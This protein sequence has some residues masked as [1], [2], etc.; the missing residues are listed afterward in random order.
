MARPRAG[1]FAGVFGGKKWFEN[2]ANFFRWDA[3]ALI[4]DC[5]CNGALCDSCCN[6]DHTVR[7]RCI[8]GIR[9]N[10]NKYLGKPLCIAEYK[11]LLRLDH[12]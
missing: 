11:T 2:L 12:S 10:V 7:F 9:E 3:V 5:Y 4:G 8:S 1:A 6:I